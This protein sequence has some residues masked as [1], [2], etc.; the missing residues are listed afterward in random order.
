MNPHG[1][2]VLRR[3]FALRVARDRA[4][5]VRV[6]DGQTIAAL[7]ASEAVMIGLLNGRRSITSLEQHFAAAFG[8]AMRPALQYAMD[9]LRPLLHVGGPAQTCPYGLEQLA[10]VKPPDPVEGIRLLP[11]PRVLHWHVTQYCPRRCS[12]CYAEPIHGSQA[13][14]AKIGSDRLATLFREAVDLGADT[15]LVSGAEPFL[16][17]DLPEVLGSAIGAGLAILLTTKYPISMSIAAR[18]ASAGVKHLSLSIDSLDPVENKWLIGSGEYGVQMLRAMRNLRS[19]GVEFSIQTVVTR[20][21]LDSIAEVG[22]LAEREGA[23][24]MQLVPFK[25]VRHPITERSNADLRLVD[26]SVIEQM[27]DRLERAFPRLRVERY[28]E[29]SNEGGFHCDIGQTKLLILPDGVIHRCYKLT[30][31]TSLRGLDLKEVSLARGWHDPAFA[32]VV[33][34]GPHAYAGSTC[35]SCGSKSKCDRSG[36]CVYDALVHHGRYAAPDRNCDG[37]RSLPTHRTIEIHSI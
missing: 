22:R 16:R 24:V 23:R 15:I 34:P 28:V 37:R 1:R 25:D 33:M 26:A 4:Y 17:D 10:S 2:L 8:D 21:N 36:R 31:D 27:R 35:S 12:Y 18:L 5:I 13:V 29:A 6:A 9:R 20:H 32:G 3:A 11:G 14:D 30:S 19:V 7:T